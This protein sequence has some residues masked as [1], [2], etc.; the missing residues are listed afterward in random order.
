MVAN[1]EPQAIIC[2]GRPQMKQKPTTIL[3]L[4][5]FVSF[6]IT[7]AT[8]ANEQ[9]SQSDESLSI[10]LPITNKLETLSL[11][12]RALN[13]EQANTSSSYPDISGDGRYIVFAS[14]ASNLVPNDTNNWQDIF[15]HDRVTKQVERVSVSS[16][17]E[18][19]NN[20]S[21]FPYISHDG[22]YVVFYSDATN[23]VSNDTNGFKDTFIH[24]R[25][26][27]E[28]ERVSVTSE[29][30]QVN[31]HSYSGIISHDGLYV[32]FASQ[33]NNLVPQ[34]TNNLWDIFIY[35]RQTKQIKRITETSNGENANGGS[36]SPVI[37]YDNQLILFTSSAN[38]LIEGDANNASDVFSYNML[39]GDINLIS[40]DSS[41][42]QGNDSSSISSLSVDGR[43]ITF[44]SR[45]TNLVLN[46]TN[47]S[48]DVFL[49][50]TQTGEVERISVDSDGFQSDGHSGNPVISLDGRYI[51]FESSATNLVADDSNGKMDVFLHDTYTG[52][53]IRLSINTEG[54]EGGKDSIDPAIS[55]NGFLVTF[56]SASENLVPNDLRL[57][58]DVFVID[59][60][61]HLR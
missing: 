15:V 16:S 53:T 32:V 33:A 46:D 41:G 50:D 8:L 6:I 24:D 18:E 12:S 30:E 38:N 2:Q 59:W 21:Y 56:S 37:S 48:F 36:H 14:G 3:L 43:Y 28:T 19:A 61:H 7:S 9:V 45:A 60:R 20:I 10:Y 58:S 42:V 47:D 5:I 13:G 34:D 22:R 40:T 44:V 57:F 11:I 29:G 23:L 27:G 4:F 1:T 54:I 55:A 17:G 31:G 52:Q 39:S 35:N 26:I 25:L 49:R 51:A